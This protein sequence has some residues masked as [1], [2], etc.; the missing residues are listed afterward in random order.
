MYSINIKAIIKIRVTAN[1]SIMEVKLNDRKAQLHQKK[2]EKS[3]DGT[4]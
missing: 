4:E 1:K 3:I 2:A